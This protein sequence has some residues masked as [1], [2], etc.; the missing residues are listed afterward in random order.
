MKMYVLLKD[1]TWY[2]SQVKY[3]EMAAGQ[4]HALSDFNA[5]YPTLRLMWH[6]LSQTALQPICLTLYGWCEMKSGEEKSKSI[7][8]ELVTPN[9]KIDITLG[10]LMYIRTLKFKSTK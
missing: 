1:K 7:L 6:F 2:W 10:N 5:L 3:G 4:Q 8:K 9:G